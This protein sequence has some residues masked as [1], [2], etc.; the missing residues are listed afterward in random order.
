MVDAAAATGQGEAEDRAAAQIASPSRVFMIAPPTVLCSVMRNS[1]AAS[2]I[3]RMLFESD[4]IQIDLFEANPGS[5]RCG[6]VERQSL[7]AVV[8]P[9]AGVFSK[10]DAPAGMWSARQAMPYWSRLTRHTASV[11]P[12]ASAIGRSF[13]ASTTPWRQSISTV[14][15][16]ANRCGRTPCCQLKR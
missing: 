4:E 8:L 12:A 13:C 2:I 9:L 15:E 16:L 6:D 5:D 1:Q 7:N 11:S 10:R 14:G 3:R